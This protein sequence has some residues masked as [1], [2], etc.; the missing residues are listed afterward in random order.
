MDGFLPHVRKQLRFN[1]R[2]TG[3]SP[4]RHTVTLAGGSELPYEYL[5][6]TMPLPVLVRLM[7]DEAPAHV[8]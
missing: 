6:S 8:R 3:V 5:I 2:I 4:T 1:S 7:G